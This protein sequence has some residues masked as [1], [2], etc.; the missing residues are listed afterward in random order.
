MIT[1]TPKI[2]AATSAIIEP[3][4]VFSSAEKYNPINR[5]E[6]PKNCVQIMHDLKLLATCCAVAAGVTSNAVTSSAPTICTILTTTNA[7]ITENASPITRT[8]LSLIHI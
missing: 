6:M 5:D 3:E 7:V 2:I 4:P 1:T 8:G